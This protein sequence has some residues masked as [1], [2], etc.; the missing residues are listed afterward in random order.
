MNNGKSIY[1]GPPSL[2]TK[3][4]SN[5]DVVFPK[6]INLADHLM[7]IVSSPTSIKDDLCVEELEKEYL[8][9]INPEIEK[10]IRHYNL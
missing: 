9:K 3:Y 7:K 10:A 1:Q 5:F 6:Y 8:L 2:I 4:F